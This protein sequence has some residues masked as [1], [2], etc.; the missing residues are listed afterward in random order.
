[1]IDRGWQLRPLQTD[2]YSGLPGVILFLAYLGDLLDRR[3]FRE[4]AESAL[5][6]LRRQVEAPGRGD[7]ANR[8]ILRLGGLLYLWTHLASLWDDPALLTEAALIVERLRGTVER[9]QDFD[10]SLGYAGAIVSLLGFFQATGDPEALDLCR[11]LGDLLV[12]RASPCG[13]GMGWVIDGMGDLPP[14]GFSHGA[15]GCAW[16]LSELFRGYRRCFLPRH[17]PPGGEI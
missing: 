3:E 15:A 10:V 5:H 14:T 13:E 1:M 4:L 11:R 12:R 17:R 6:T 7:E 9:N 2:L 16:A 8:R